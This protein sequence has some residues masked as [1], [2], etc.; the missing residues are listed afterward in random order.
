MP[1]EY[2]VVDYNNVDFV[3][4]IHEGQLSIMSMYKVDG[5]N[6]IIYAN[7]VQSSLKSFD[8]IIWSL[9]CLSF[10][11]FAALFFIR[12]R[13]HSLKKQ[14]YSPLFE[15]FSHMISEETTDFSDRSGRLIST[16][17]TLGFFFILEFY[18]I[19][20]STDLVVV[21]KPQVINN[22]R[23]VMDEKNATVFFYAFMYDLNE[24]VSAEK[25]V[26]L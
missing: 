20:M 2:P 14:G 11:V 19:L 9:I 6:K 25:E 15:A 12:K 13:T 21:N 7:L 17:V 3:Q 18:F 10:F 5:F 1:V 16:L 23:D 22:Y 4:V 24:F 8:S 26:L